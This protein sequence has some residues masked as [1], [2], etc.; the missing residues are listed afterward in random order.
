MF[1]IL[2]NNLVLSTAY[3]RG[4]LLDPPGSGG[5]DTQRGKKRVSCPL[6]APVLVTWT[7]RTRMFQHSGGGAI[8][9]ECTEAVKTQRRTIYKRLEG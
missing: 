9:E 1:T 6:G 8:G 5:W 7:D 4:V 2:F 3:I